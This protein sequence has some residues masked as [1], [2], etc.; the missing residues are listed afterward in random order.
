MPQGRLNIVGTGYLVAGQVTPQ[1]SVCIQR[2]D[3]LFY[4][5]PDPVTRAWI[6]S[7][8]S[9][10]ESL[11]DT[12]GLDKER[13][14]SYYEM[15]ERMLSPVRQGLEVCGAFYGH[16][17]V[18]AFPTHEAIRRARS[19]G[20]EAWM[21]PG[22]SAA[23]CL[24][25]DLGL[26]PSTDGCQMYEASQF[27]YRRRRIDPASMLIL[28][29]VGIIGIS[30]CPVEP[31]AP[32]VLRLLVEVLSHDYPL[33]HEVVIYEAAQLP[34]CRPKVLRVALE[35]LPT[36]GVTGFS[37]LLVPPRAA[38]ETD[39]AIVERLESLQT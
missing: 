20:F 25:A 28:W 11:A 5:L 1:A 13:L 26:D 14:D 9:T 36:A 30:T 21:L 35:D 16:P 7:L 32:E 24:F 27:L 29:Q 19:E 22:I 6:E 33:D 3:K 38:A 15:V 2:A 34:V 39:W 12:Y 31:C 17:G 23:D 37:T 18:F 8:N 10:A 4:L